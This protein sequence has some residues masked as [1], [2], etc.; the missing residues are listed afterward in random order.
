MYFQLDFLVYRELDFC[1]FYF[2]M[3]NEFGLKSKQLF[4][5][6]SQFL[7]NPKQRKIS[8]MIHAYLKLCRQKS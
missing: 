2:V 6:N 5:D 3:K 1:H 4:G 7:S 8:S